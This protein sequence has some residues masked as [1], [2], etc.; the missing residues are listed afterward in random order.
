M[1]H[2]DTDALRA[3]IAAALEETPA[4]PEE[5]TPDLD[6]DDLAARMYGKPYK[7]DQLAAIADRMF[8]H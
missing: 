6:T 8:R 1:R 3:R 5:P 7:G 2:I 4:E